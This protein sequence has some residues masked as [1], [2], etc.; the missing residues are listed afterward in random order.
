MWWV[1]SHPI[2]LDQSLVRYTKSQCI[3]LH[4]PKPLNFFHW[5]NLLRYVYIHSSETGSCDFLHYNIM[6]YVMV[7][8]RKQWG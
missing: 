3:L 6:Y 7:F 2:N 5:L 4:H 8:E 1:A